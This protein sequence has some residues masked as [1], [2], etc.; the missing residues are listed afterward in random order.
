RAMLIIVENT[1]SKHFGEHAAT[2]EVLRRH[3]AAV[4]YLRV[5]AV[6]GDLR[7]ATRQEDRPRILDVLDFAAERTGIEEFRHAPWVT[8]G[9]S[10]RG[11]FPFTMAWAYPER[12]IAGIT[13]HG[14]T[15]TWPPED[16]ARPQDE[17]VLYV[18]V[19]GQT[20]WGGTWNRHVRPSLLNYRRKTGWLA[21]QVVVRGVGHGDYPDAHGSSGWGKQFPDRVT[22]IDVWDYLAVFLDKA[23]EARL[24]EDGYPTEGPLKL[25]QPDEADGWLIDKFGVERMLNLRPYRLVES[26]GLYVVDPAEDEHQGGYAA[27]PPAE[28]FAPADGVPVTTL[29]SSSGPKRWLATEPVNHAVADDP[30]VEYGDLPDLRPRP[31]T[32]IT[33]GG[34][35]TTFTPLNESYVD[36]RGD[37]KLR[38]RLQK[39]D[40][41]TLLAYTVL[42]VD[43]Q[44][45]VKLQAPYT[46]NGR[47]QVFL[48][49]RPVK[50]EQVIELKPGLYP[51]L[52]ALR[53]RTKW[54]KLSV[55]FAP[56]DEQD[57]QRAKEL[58]AK[59]DRLTAESAESDVSAISLRRR[60][61]PILQKAS[62][63]DETDRSDRFWVTDEEL[64]E[65]WRRLHQPPSESANNGHGE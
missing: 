46:Q 2:R 61:T 57:I 12:T 7:R 25:R 38:D 5:S 8:F 1:D 11:K 4:V 50:H 33:L 14:E 6:E 56:A 36:N 27:V 9:K 62:E 52:A 34:H 65:H 54:Q 23:L 29:N 42:E 30:M 24:P 37:I 18:C 48:S 60:E 47:V 44:R 58:Q 35:T 16:W 15:P 55:S 41:L 64:A 28:D 63:V 53:L 45:H 49:G 3:E 51:M 39:H 43:R 31:G 26:D 20:E 19:N 22:C 10:S 13:Y 32:E 21:H 59:R 40:E 17:S